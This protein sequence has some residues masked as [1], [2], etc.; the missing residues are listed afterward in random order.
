[1]KIPSDIEY[2]IDEIYRKDNNSFFKK[3]DWKDTE[4]IYSDL[5]KLLPEAHIVNFTDYNYDHCYTY[6]I[7]LSKNLNAQKINQEFLDLAIKEEKLID[8]LL[9]KI[10][11]IAPYY[12]IAAQRYEFVN[13]EI[14]RSPRFNLQKIDTEIIESIHILLKKQ[15]LKY[16]YSE[17]ADLIVKDVETELCKKG[18]ATVSDCIFGT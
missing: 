15:K 11:R 2:I 6:Q 10:S 4:G 9:L 17:I 13:E 16:L 3:V 7:I 18:E 14:I 1:M 12:T 5:V 8:I